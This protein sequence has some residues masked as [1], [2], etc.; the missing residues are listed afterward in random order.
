MKKFYFL[1]ALVAG[2]AL[3]SC[4]SEDDLALSPPEVNVEDGY[5]P[6]VFSSQK[7][8]ITRGDITGKDAAILLNNK[9]VVSGF[10]GE[11]TAS[12]GSIVFDNYVVEW[13]ENTAHTTESN[14]SNWE[15][16]D[17][18]LIPH[19]VTNGITKQTIKY[20]DYSKPQYDFIAWAVG[21]TDEGAEITAIYDN[22]NLEDHQVRVSA[23]APNSKT[24]GWLPDITEGT[25]PDQITYARPSYTFEGKAEDLSHCYISDIV[26]VNK[27]DAGT[28]GEVG[29]YGKP[30]TL[31]F[32]QLGTKVRIA[33]YETVPG[34]SVKNVEFY[35]AATGRL[36]EANDP[37]PDNTGNYDADEAA[38]A[39]ASAKIFTTV[40][41][42]IY[43]EGTY[44]V[45]FPTVDSPDD[46]DNN[47]AHIKFS[48]RTNGASTDVAQKTTVDWGAVNYT[49]REEA[50]KLTTNSYLGRTSNTASFAGNKDD[51]YYVFYLPN[52]NGTNLNLRVNFTLESIDGSGEEIVVKGATAQ[53]PSIY[54]TWKP[55]YAYTYLFK[56][57]DKTNGHTGAYDPMNPYDTSL[58]SD[59]A[60]LYP[61]TFDAVV[62]NA[63]EG[64]TT[65]ETITLV[66]T[67]SIT[68]YQNGSNV[69][70]KNEYTY[71][72][73]DGAK[74][75]GEIYVTVNDSE[76][77]YAAVS[78]NAGDPVAGLYTKSGDDYI[79]C[80]ADAVAVN[81]TTYYQM[82]A[83]PKLEDADLATLTDK[84]MLYEV[85]DGTTE[86]QVID[87]LQYR[88]DDG[89]TASPVVITGRNEI[90]LTQTTGEQVM[91]LTNQVTYGVDGN[92]ITVG[93]DKAAKFIPENANKTYAFVYTK[94]ASSA[95]K[96]LYQQISY[97]DQD[98]STKYRYATTQIQ[99]A[100]D[101]QKDVVY[102]APVGNPSVL[103]K[104]DVFIGQGVG[105]LYVDNG[106]DK[107]A[108]SGYAKTGTNYYYT[109]D[110][111]SSYIQAENIN[112]A[113]F[114]KDG[115][116]QLYVL[117]GAY[118]IPKT[119]NAPVD[120]TAYYYRKGTA[121]N[122]T[123][124]Y[125]VILPEQT[126]TDWYTVDYPYSY[127]QV[128][129]NEE[130]MV[131]MK[132]FDMYTK[133][134]GVYYS[135]VIKIAAAN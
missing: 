118:Y 124:T 92:T 58:N 12:P 64:N 54:T 122:Y 52:E 130:K 117:S 8:N 113:D 13:E 5:A 77:T 51:N 6:I 86:A 76:P 83:T 78:K 80:A 90:V 79:P 73:N 59:P 14:S 1:A 4:T 84:V 34:Y 56:I 38:A 94:Q 88:E 128:G 49:G 27:G 43:S 36:V 112:Y 85:A 19:A 95:T 47:Q 33:I 2:T 134:N 26:T 132:Y 57:S 81:G 123:Y 69:V 60:G 114:N 100:G 115:D 32:R 22:A 104:Q 110:N 107:V 103:T 135:K 127:V 82:T 72:A 129:A 50:E 53:V 11:A 41:N 37:K 119:E 16:V 20:W 75:T 62:V 105:N 61:I 31:K 108:A 25:A 46:A 55:G 15:Y 10:K 71:I 133:N 42:Q 131:G 101:V 23:I 111:G 17:K 68:T 45:Y 30:V 7:N 98:V 24:N 109:L 67:P 35:S 18:N 28:Y 116:D 9:F 63:E 3:T 106:T 99:T 44:T 125:C 89:T 29:G 21:K 70:N 96:D 87:A 102:F 126:T 121:G 66:S 39:N 93:T 48:P 91:N 97:S 40:S 120:G 65:Q 74:I